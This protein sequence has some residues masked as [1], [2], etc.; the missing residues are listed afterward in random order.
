MLWETVEAQDALR[1]RFGFD[2][3]DA[4]AQWLIA[5]LRDGW[6]IT[7]VEVRRVVLSDQN[8][9]AW[10]STDRGA[11]VVKWSRAEALFPVL[12]ATTVVLGTLGTRG[13]PVAAPLPAVGG[14][15]RLVRTGPRG[16]LSVAVLP[17]LSGDWL[18]ITDE[19][20]VRDAGACLAR[21]HEALADCSGDR[22]PRGARTS[23]SPTDI[24]H[25]VTAEG[26]RLPDDVARRLD[27]LL[28]DL[29]ELDDRPQLVHQD[30][31][32]ANLLVRD[33]RV[34]G[35]LDFDELGIGRRV[36]DLAH[37]S[38]Y[39]ATR[40]TDWGP[41]PASIQQQLR[42]GYESVRPLGK[43]ERHWWDVLVLWQGLRAFPSAT[44]GR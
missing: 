21:L 44:A 15:V 2:D 36:H 1:D 37:A 38:V 30:Y 39:L 43:A 14:R 10:A 17:E 31:R 32:A 11:L 34:V 6:A 28:T 26:H 3:L 22:L 8:A 16:P 42:T 18:D 27:E 23:A 29:P 13:L 5:T 24:R 19:S 41:T 25:W 33:G 9:I 20:A 12:E 40:F 7:A 35:V 4:V